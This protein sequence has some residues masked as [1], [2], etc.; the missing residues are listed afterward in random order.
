MMTFEQAYEQYH[1]MLH[2]YL[3]IRTRNQALA[4]DLAQLAMV[5]A[6]QHWDSIRTEYLQAWLFTI[7]R[8]SLLDYRRSAAVRYS[9]PLASA[10][11]V[12]G[13]DPHEDALDSE[14]RERI[15]RTFAGMKEKYATALRLTLDGGNLPYEVLAERAGVSRD[16]FKHWVSRGRRLFAEAWQAQEVSA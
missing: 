2:S 6:W 1:P 10:A 16:L 14:E 7:A 9:L 8:N 3:L 5:K 13:G 11:N 15:E 4:D 12:S